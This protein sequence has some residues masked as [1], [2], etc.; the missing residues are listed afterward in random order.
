ML[1]E[2]V[3]GTLAAPAADWPEARLLAATGWRGTTRLAHGDPTMGA[4][5]L[6]SNAEAVTAVL[7]EYRDRLDEWIALL[8]A[9]GGGDAE[10]LRARLAE[11]RSRLEE[12]A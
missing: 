7:R 12:P 3:A 9:P 5:I 11:A 2:A 10:V 6:A 4:E 8:S 1:V